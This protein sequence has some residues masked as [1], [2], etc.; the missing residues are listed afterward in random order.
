MKELMIYA[1]EV[2]ACGGVL[3]GAYTIL[4]ERRVK[5]RWCRAYLLITTFLAVIIP[6]LRIPVWAGEV[7]EAVATP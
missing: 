5:S 6:L 3:L 7:I 2:L 1:L 4:L